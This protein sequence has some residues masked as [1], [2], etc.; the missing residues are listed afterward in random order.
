MLWKTAKTNK[1]KT[2]QNNTI[3][4]K[5]MITIENKDHDIHISTKH[6]ERKKNKTVFNNVKKKMMK[7]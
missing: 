4:Q 6:K 1:Q 3:K 5:K 2:K 7:N